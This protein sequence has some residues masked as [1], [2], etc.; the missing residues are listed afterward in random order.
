MFRNIKYSSLV[1]AIESMS[2]NQSSQPPESYSD[3]DV[4]SLAK[5]LEELG[6]SL[7]AKQ[8][9]L[10]Q[11]LIDGAESLFRQEIKEEVI[12]VDKQIKDAAISA[13]KPFIHSKRGQKDCY[14]WIRRG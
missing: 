8:R 6:N 3:E 11:H 7:P 1:N 5:R 9:E 10:L 4:H 12:V 2:T 14:F 13:L